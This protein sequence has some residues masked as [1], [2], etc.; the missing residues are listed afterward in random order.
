VG[1]D[2]RSFAAFGRS[3]AAL[4]VRSDLRLSIAV[5]DYVHTR[6]RGRGVKRSPSL[7]S[8]QL[9]LLE[10]NRATLEPFL[11]YCEE[12]GA[13]ERRLAPDELF[14]KETAFEVRI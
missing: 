2:E 4:T 14:P 12:Q 5:S 13:T 11:M 9:D 10:P 7:V 8:P 6:S 3:H 1:G